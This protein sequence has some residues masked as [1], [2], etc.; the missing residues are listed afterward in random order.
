MPWLVPEGYNVDIVVECGAT[1]AWRGVEFSM[2]QHP[3]QTLYHHLIWFVVDGLRYLCIGD[4]VSGLGFREKRD[5]IHSFLRSRSR[6][7]FRPLSSPTPCP[8][9]PM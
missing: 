9:S 2:E 1:F 8:S 7:A 3:G 4:N 6:P 5:F